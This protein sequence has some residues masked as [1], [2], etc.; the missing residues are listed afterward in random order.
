MRR[1]TR[2]RL[3][4]GLIA[5]AIAMTAL[6]GTAQ[7]RPK[8]NQSRLMIAAQLDQYRPANGTTA[9]ALKSVKR[10]Q[11][12]LNRKNIN[13]AVDGQYG[14]QTLFGFAAWQRRIGFHDRMVNG[15]P[16]YVALDKLLGDR[17]GISH[18]VI[19]GPRLSYQGQV[20]NQRTVAMLQAAGKR[21]GASCVL[22][23]VKGSYT[24]PDSLSSGT[25][26][27]GGAVDISVRPENRC[28]RRIKRMVRALRAVGF[29]AWFRNWSGNEHIHASAISD[30]SMATEITVPGW[31]DTRDQ[32]A[33][34]AQGG[35]GLNTPGAAPMTRLPLR[36]WEAYAG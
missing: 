9:G 21:L 28:G 13:V 8:V 14:V 26:A 6:A 34:W 10:V 16:G 17:F 23:V 35:D 20:L 27:G 29:A 5:C 4:A 32:I 24:G 22:T 30:P 3:A 31:L 11:R 7:A 1:S 12:A 36:T 33:S 15:L 2:P 18:R 19:Q 25:H